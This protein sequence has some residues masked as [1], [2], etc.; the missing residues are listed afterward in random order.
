MAVKRAPIGTQEQTRTGLRKTGK[1]LGRETSTQR[2][3][4]NQKITQANTMLGEQDDRQTDTVRHGGFCNREVTHE[5][6][7]A[8]PP[9]SFLNTHDISG[10]LL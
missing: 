2:Q 10:N 9:G 1:H 3:K 4:G 6:R 7:V 5:V 8:P